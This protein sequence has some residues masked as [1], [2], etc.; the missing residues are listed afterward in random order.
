[1]RPLAQQTCAIKHSRLM[2]F[3]PTA[4]V[5]AFRREENFSGFAAKRNR[6]QRKNNQFI[7]SFTFYVLIPL[8]TFAFL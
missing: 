5:G 4:P 7:A 1:V 3:P 8:I 6:K 2:S